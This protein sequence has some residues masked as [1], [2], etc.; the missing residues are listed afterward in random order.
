MEE[1]IRSYPE[2]L[3]TIQT[4]IAEMVEDKD[5]RWHKS[6]LPRVE[7]LMVMLEITPDVELMLVGLKMLGYDYR[8]VYHSSN[9]NYVAVALEYWYEDNKGLEIWAQHYKVHD[10]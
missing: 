5:L 10:D 8:D 7:E 9:T 6:S 4:F 2:V 1:T 3:L